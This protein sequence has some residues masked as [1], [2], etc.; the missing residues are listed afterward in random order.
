M[1]AP[2]STLTPAERPPVGLFSAIVIVAALGYFV[3]IYDLVLFSIIRVKSLN[4]IGVTDPTA[5]T[6]QGL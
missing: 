1:N 3:D 4:G 5:V 2:H 6:D